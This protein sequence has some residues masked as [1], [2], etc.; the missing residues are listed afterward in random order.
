VSRSRSELIER[1]FRDLNQRNWDDL[2]EVVPPEFEFHSTFA[3][4]EGGRIYRGIDEFLELMDSFFATWEVLTWH[5]AEARHGTDHSVTLYRVTGIAA[6]S[7]VPLDQS[8][9]MLWTWD[10]DSPIRGEVFTSPQEAMS[11]A[12]LSS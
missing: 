1:V 3:A 2:R 8:M 5:L 11:A 4:L 9:A 6:G 12:G 10:G 7:R